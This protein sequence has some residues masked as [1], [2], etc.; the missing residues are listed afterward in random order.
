VRHCVP[1]PL[2]TV[3]ETA[4]VHPALIHNF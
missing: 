3:F 1:F 4:A 2:L